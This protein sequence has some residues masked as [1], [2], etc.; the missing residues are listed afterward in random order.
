MR[1]ITASDAPVFTAGGWARSRGWIEIKQTV[2]GRTARVIAEPEVT[3]VGSALLAAHALGR[4]PDVT[5]A[6]RLL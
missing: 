1:T 6:A 4:Q 3:A 5:T 2:T